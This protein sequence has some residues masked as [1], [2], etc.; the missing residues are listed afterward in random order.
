MPRKAKCFLL[1][2][3]GKKWGSCC[4]IPLRMLI[5]KCLRPLAISKCSFGQFYWEHLHLQDIIHWDACKRLKRALIIQVVDVNLEIFHFWDE[6][7][8]C[9]GI[10]LTAAA[11]KLPLAE[12]SRLFCSGGLSQEGFFLR[13][14]AQTVSVFSDEQ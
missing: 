1:E 14:E 6:K 7:L 12:L 11:T 8:S 9:C 2:I 10:G 3:K 5:L 4:R 13:I